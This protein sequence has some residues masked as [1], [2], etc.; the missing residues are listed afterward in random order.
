M[1]GVIVV[2]AGRCRS[3]N[4]GRDAYNDHCLDIVMI[5]WSSINC[6]TVICLPTVCYFSGEKP[7]VKLTA[8]GSLFI[9]FAFAIYF[10]LHLFSDLLNHKYKNTL[11][12]FICFCFVLCFSNLLYLSLSDHTIAIDREGI[13]NPF[14]ALGA[15][16]LIFCAGI[17]DLCVVS[18]WIDTLLVL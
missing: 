15:S 3:A 16:C 12:Q 17:G 6:P 11:L 8:L 1:C 2:D 5:I 4:L 14:I 7:L 10:T 13:D 9:I 18:Y